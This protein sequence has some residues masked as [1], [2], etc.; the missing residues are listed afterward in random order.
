[1]PG[2]EKLFDTEQEMCFELYQHICGTCLNGEE[3]YCGDDEPVR[4]DPPNSDDYKE[5]LGTSCG[6]EFEVE[7][8]PEGL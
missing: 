8:I 4:G 2:W 3:Y 7:E 1:M 6:C 5:L